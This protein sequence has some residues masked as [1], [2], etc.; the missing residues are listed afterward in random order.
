ML[1]WQFVSARAIVGRNH[2]FGGMDF[3][4]I[5]QAPG[6][7]GFV[8]ERREP[9]GESVAEPRKPPGESVAERRKP[10]GEST[11]RRRN[12]MARAIPL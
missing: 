1:G 7:L 5:S 9:P 10:P 2:W 12:R 3:I 11:I 8:A 4:R 6:F